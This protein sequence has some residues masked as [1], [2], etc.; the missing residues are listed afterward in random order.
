M[1]EGGALRERAKERTEVV[2]CGGAT[3]SKI[4]ST[5]FLRQ[6]DVKNC[7]CNFLGDWGAQES[8]GG[9]FITTT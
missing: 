2:A 4:P 7:K 6:A 5:S 3:S 8:R 9:G 1:G